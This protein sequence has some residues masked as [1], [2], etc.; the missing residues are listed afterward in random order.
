M[1]CR[2]IIMGLK[3]FF[4]KYTRTACSLVPQ[5]YTI[6]AGGR[7]RI[8]LSQ[9]KDLSLH[10]FSYPINFLAFQLNIIH[11]CRQ[12]RYINCVIAVVQKRSVHR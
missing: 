9:K 3:L 5:L 7:P 4:D 6:Q 1:A 2:P 12:R 10:K 11:A 8:Y